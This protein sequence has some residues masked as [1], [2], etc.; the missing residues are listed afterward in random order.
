[1]AT[2]AWD[3]GLHNSNTPDVSP[4]EKWA[5]YISSPTYHKLIGNLTSGLPEALSYYDT[6][7]FIS[8]KHSMSMAVLNNINHTAL[9]W[10]LSSLEIFVRANT[11]KLIQGWIPTSASLSRQGREESPIFPRCQ[12]T[13]ETIDHIHQCTCTITISSRQQLLQIYIK[14]LQERTPQLLHN[15]LEYKLS[16]VLELPTIRYHHSIMHSS[17]T[18]PTPI[19]V[20][21]RHLNIAGWDCFLKGFISMYWSSAYLMTRLASQKLQPHDWSVQVVTAT[22]EIYVH[23]MTATNIYMDLPRWNL[24]WNYARK[25]TTKLLHFLAFPQN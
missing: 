15:T 3:K 20:A 8:K 16:L 6:L 7:S 11:V 9:K 22:V 13:V 10:Y 4:Y 12:S 19:L 18:I 23:G 5:I 21:I 14:K 25:F 2:A 1:M 17:Q 24:I